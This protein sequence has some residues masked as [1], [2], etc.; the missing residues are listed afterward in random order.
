MEKDLMAAIIA[1]INVYVQEEEIEKEYIE[2]TND[3]PRSDNSDISPWRMFGRQRGV[4]SRTT[5][6][7]NKVH[8]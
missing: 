2:Y 1:A 6:R 7:V 4:I 8:R 3:A 5:W